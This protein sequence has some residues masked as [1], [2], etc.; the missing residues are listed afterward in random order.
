VASKFA[1]GADVVAYLA[2]GA[3]VA[4]DV[5]TG[6]KMWERPLG[7]AEPVGIAQADNRVFVTVLRPTPTRDASRLWELAALD[8]RTGQLVWRRDSR[9]SLGAPAAVGGVVAVPLLKQWVVFLT[10]ANG[11]HLARVR[12]AD[13]EV[14][15]VEVMDGKF[16]FGSARGIRAVDARAATSRRASSTST[17]LPLPDS[18]SRALPARDAFD[19]VHGQFSAYDRARV[20][21]RV[22]AVDRALAFTGNQVVVHLEKVFFALGV[23]TGSL[24]WAHAAATPAV[25]AEDVGG[26]ILFATRAGQ[27]R[28][29]ISSTG[30]VVDAGD[31][32]VGVLGASFDAAGFA[33]RPDGV[34]TV[35]RPREALVAMAL[36]RDAR[37]RGVQA[38][39]ASALGGLPG[40]QPSEDLLRIIDDE[41]TPEEVRAAAGEALVSRRVAEAAPVLM[42]SLEQGPDFLTNRRPRSTAAAARALAALGQ[43]LS[44]GDQARARIVVAERLTDPQTDEG[45]LA[46]LIGA[47]G[48]LPGSDAGE[49]VR[50]FLVAYRAD[51]AFAADP[52]PLQ[53]AVELLLGGS[54]YDR[55]VVAFVALDARTL[56]ALRKFAHE[57]LYR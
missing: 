55:E 27:L 41:S 38:F 34:T 54:T 24:R 20:L 28:G 37:F 7:V 18:L 25:S 19:P 21:W 51:P 46:A 33:P 26:V 39:A 36:D 23:D 5:A 40:A 56:P 57:K 9:G 14:L 53:A 35:T 11:G 13:E 42:A 50:A 47:L 1:P 22:R 44:P 31:V 45:D 30:H 3:V 2:R 16:Y 29:L 12:S 17:V 15:F 8:A 52:R 49:A 48:A 4:R 32:P 43:E 10:G 6:V